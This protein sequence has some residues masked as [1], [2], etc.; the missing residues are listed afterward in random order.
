MA[1]TQRHVMRFVGLAI[2]LIVTAFFVVPMIWLFLAPTKTDGQLLTE[3]PFAFGS[4][5]TFAHTF[6]RVVTYS[7]TAF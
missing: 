4:L 1:L 5:N 6:H 7:T 3:S 2:L